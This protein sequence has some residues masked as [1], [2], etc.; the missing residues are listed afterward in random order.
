MGFRF[1]KSFKIAPGMKFNLNK[2]SHSF[3]FGGK[4]IHYT[5]NS[6]GKRTKSFG[7]PG[8]GL[9]YTDTKSRKT[10]EKEGDEP[11]GRKSNKNSSGGCLGFIIMLVLL[12]I[13]LVA[14]S[15]LWIPAIPLLIYFITS[16]KNRQYRVRNVSIC[17]IVLITSVIVFA[18]LG[19]S[20]EL[21]SI[22]AEWGKEEFYIGDITEV[23]ITANPSDAD[24]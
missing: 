7:I 24:I 18:W 13:A 17:S 8:T 2:N 9:Y 23:K 21:N 19:S 15:L 1:R 14:Y 10:K 6:N 12:S 3:T 16:K 20:P 11:M 5:V 22:S 4:G